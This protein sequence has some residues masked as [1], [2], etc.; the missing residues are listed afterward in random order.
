MNATPSFDFC[1]HSVNVIVIYIYISLSQ[2][3][4][5]QCVSL[6]LKKVLAYISQLMQP[7]L[8]LGKQLL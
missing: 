5:T 6:Q 4:S 2:S 1:F 3:E 8:W 7:K